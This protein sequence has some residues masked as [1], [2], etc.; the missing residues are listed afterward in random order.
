MYKPNEECTSVRYVELT[1]EQIRKIDGVCFCYSQRKDER[2]VWIIKSRTP[3]ALFEINHH[4]L[5]QSGGGA[6][7]WIIPRV[8]H[9]QFNL[10]KFAQIWFAWLNQCLGPGTTNSIP[11]KFLR[12]L[13][14]RVTCYC[15]QFP[16]YPW[17]RQSLPAPKYWKLSTRWKLT[18]SQQGKLT[19]IRYI[20]GIS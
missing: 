20:A 18:A 2:F 4:D 9:I 12:A 7:L 8:H 13:Y 19:A 10:V 5:F 17:W 16:S 6:V 3:F 11:Y 14:I 1:D 15:S